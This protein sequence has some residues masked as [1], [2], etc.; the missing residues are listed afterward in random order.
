[1]IIGLDTIGDFHVQSKM[2]TSNNNK[3]YQVEMQNVF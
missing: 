2:P 3:V 1:M